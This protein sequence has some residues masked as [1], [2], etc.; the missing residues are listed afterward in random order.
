MEDVKQ[1]RAKIPMT[2]YKWCK[3]SGMSMTDICTFSLDLL[4]KR[5]VIVYQIISVD[6]NCVFV[7]RFCDQQARDVNYHYITS[8]GSESIGDKIRKHG[9]EKFTYEIISS[10][11]TVVLAEVMIRGLK[12]FYKKKGVK[13]HEY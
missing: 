6:L 2:T 11:S 7:G 10:F 12:I 8:L 1:I 13:V 9:Q 3:S 5:P 4:A